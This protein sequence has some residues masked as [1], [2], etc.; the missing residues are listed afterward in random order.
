MKK[1]LSLNELKVKSFVTNQ[2]TT[3]KETVKGGGWSNPCPYYTKD[4][5]CG[6]TGFRD[7]NRTEV[8]VCG[9]LTQNK[10]CY[11]WNCEPM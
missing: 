8:L 5:F 4:V 6:D 9:Q 10:D 11:S 2:E 1:K 7:C 3:V